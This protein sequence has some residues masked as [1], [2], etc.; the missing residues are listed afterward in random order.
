[1]KTN[2]GKKVKT[3]IRASSLSHYI[4]CPR[5]AAAKMFPKELQSLGFEITPVNTSAGAAVGT[6]THNALEAALQLKGNGCSYID[7]I[8][9]VARDSMNDS[10]SKGI[11]WDD[12][13]FDKET[14]VIQAVRQARVV[15]DNF[16]NLEQ[17]S[18]EDEFK[19]DLGDD[20]TLSGHIDIRGKRSEK[21]GIWDLKTGTVKRI[22]SPQYGA[23]SLLVR[24]HGIQVDEL[25]EIYVKRVGKSK[26]QPAPVVTQFDPAEAEEFAKSI[27]MKIK[28]DLMT[29]RKTGK[30]WV[31][32]PN[33][34][35]MMCSHNYC[36]AYGTN[37]C[38]CK[39]KEIP[40]E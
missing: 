13:T 27:I 38:N 12:T 29:F 26:P 34:N 11:I 24:S 1:M 10:I 28:T 16:P 2:Q 25:G 8:Q 21:F 9:K 7:A 32:I 6:A 30:I 3:V 39:K 4:D 22:N 23:Y 14:G 31:W 37:F 40:H 20:F 35:S 17:I 5:R 36:P 15:L 19:A 18:I 33:P